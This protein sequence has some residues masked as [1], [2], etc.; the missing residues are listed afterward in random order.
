MPVRLGE[1]WVLEKDAVLIEAQLPAIEQLSRY[2][3]EAAVKSQAPDVIVIP[4][5]LATD[6]SGECKARWFAMRVHQ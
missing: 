3:R 4:A 2:G 5:V 1:A 6:L